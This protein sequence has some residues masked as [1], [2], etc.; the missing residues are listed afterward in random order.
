VVIDLV[1]LVTG[2]AGFIGSAVARML[3]TGGET[4]VVVDKLTYA[5]DLR[6]LEAI[7]DSGRLFFEQADI[8]DGAAIARILA[9]YAPVTILH[10]AAESQV[11]RSIDGP[12][13]F[14]Q[15]NIFGTYEL[16]HQAVEHWRGL[17]EPQRQCFR[18]VHVSTDEVY[19]A[20]GP[21]GV[22]TESTPFA[23]VRAPRCGRRRQRKMA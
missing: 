8:C 13:S 22:F 5:A 10:L 11:D 7:S 21:T 2:G 3:A 16:L 20:L 6:R 18:F 9:H 14:V 23:P 4:V 12:A 19:G 17:A 1:Y 15:S